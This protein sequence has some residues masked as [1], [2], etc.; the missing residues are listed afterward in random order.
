VDPRSL[1]LDGL[2]L[3]AVAALVTSLVLGGDPRGVGGPRR[4]GAWL[5]AAA[6]AGWMLWSPP[7][8]LTGSGPRVAADW[9]WF[10]TPVLA[11]AAGVAGR[12]PE[13]SRLLG[14]ALFATGFAWLAYRAPRTH[15]WSAAQT[16]VVVAG[17][18]VAAAALWTAAR[19]GLD[20]AR[21]PAALTA[22]AAWSGGASVALTATGSLSYGMRLAPL[23]T[24]LAVLAGL[25]WVGRGER[26]AGAVAGLAAPLTLGMLALAV[27]FSATPPWLAGLLA[28][29]PLLARALPRGAG[30]AGPRAVP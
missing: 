6:V 2:L 30:T 14:R 27:V 21:A 20:G 19:R 17:G 29:A 24:T 13:A 8:T 16:A 26:A 10:A 25:S 15:T 4:V 23:S 7:A 12:V 5:A 9:L 3:P 28:L 22:L 11:V 1:A 18:G